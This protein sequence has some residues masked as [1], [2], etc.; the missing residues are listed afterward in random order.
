MKKKT[1]WLDGL[2]IHITENGKA[3]HIHHKNKPKHPRATKSVQHRQHKDML[4]DFIDDLKG[5]ID[6]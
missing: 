4:V 5:L 2:K 3:I 6:G 1:N